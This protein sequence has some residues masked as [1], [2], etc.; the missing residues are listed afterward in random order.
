MANAEPES[1]NLVNEECVEDNRMDEVEVLEESGSGTVQNTNAL[2]AELKKMLSDIGQRFRE[3]QPELIEVKTIHRVKEREQLLFGADVLGNNVA[4]IRGMVAALGDQI[5]MSRAT[6]SERNYNYQKREPRLGKSGSVMG[7]TTLIVASPMSA[8]LNAA[9]KT[10]ILEHDG[11]KVYVRRGRSQNWPNPRVWILQA[12]CARQDL[13]DLWKSILDVMRLVYV[14]DPNA[15]ES[16]PR[17]AEDVLLR[18]LGWT[19]ELNSSFGAQLE[20]EDVDA[21]SFLEEKL[22]M[23]LKILPCRIKADDESTRSWP[24]PSPF[25]TK[26]VKLHVEGLETL[27]TGA[28][29]QQLFSTIGTVT[30]IQ[31]NYME[32]CPSATVTVPDIVT[33]RKLIQ[34]FDE[35]DASE[36]IGTGKLRLTPEAYTGPVKQCVC[37]KRHK[38]TTC[39]EQVV[40]ILCKSD[41]HDVSFCPQMHSIR[42]EIH[43]ARESAVYR[44]SISSGEQ[45]CC[46]HCRQMDCS[47]PCQW[48]VEWGQQHQMETV[49]KVPFTA[50]ETSDPLRECHEVVFCWNSYADRT[51][52]AALV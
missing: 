29:I 42:R 30:R 31:I 16:H 28:D 35:F 51:R 26:P 49:M 14:K 23:V 38:E 20:C 34:A 40:C 11:Q 6:I 25:L 52:G 44:G 41:R 3:K 45:K 27:V 19:A 24:A 22:Q 17:V 36:T 18:P 47:I 46:G 13:P 5:V 43:D 37:G 50:E 33:A 8:E 9:V 48:S 4:K 1:A 39:P 7:V 15:K 12:M 2:D 32:Q 21:V 10:G